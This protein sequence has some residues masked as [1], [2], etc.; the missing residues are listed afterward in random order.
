M[1]FG[2][3]APKL[4]TSGRVEVRLTYWYIEAIPEL[5]APATDLLVKPHRPG[6]ER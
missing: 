4:A 5:L 1:D 6:A 3:E 2:R